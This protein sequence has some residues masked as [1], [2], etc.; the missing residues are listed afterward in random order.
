[1]KT[2]LAVDYFG[3]KAAIADAL[4]IKKSAVSQWGD[5]IPKGRAYQIEVLTGGKLKADQHN[6]AQGRA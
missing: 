3:T 2:V 6:T 1:M 5:T 4:G